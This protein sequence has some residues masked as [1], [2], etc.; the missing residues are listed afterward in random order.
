VTTARVLQ[1]DCFETLARLPNGAVQ[2]VIT[3]PPYTARST[4]ARVVRRARPGERTLSDGRV[5]VSAE[6]GAQVGAWDESTLVRFAT[7]CLRVSQRWVVIF[8]ELESLGTFARL[9]GFVRSMIWDRHSTPQITGDRPAQ[10]AEGIAVLRAAPSPPGLLVRALRLYGGEVPSNPEPDTLADLIESGAVELVRRADADGL[11]E[12]PT[13]MALLHNAGRKRWNGGGK[14]G[15]YRHPVERGAG[16]LHPAQKPGK[17]I[18]DLI[19]DFTDPG[20]TILDPCCGVGTIPA[21]AAGAGRQGAGFESHPVW[22]RRA[23]MRV[24]GDPAWCA[25][26]TPEEQAALTAPRPAA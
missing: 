10:P 23:A 17:L 13:A 11:T 24:S 2:H 22:A 3:D 8:C 7:E 26:L 20:D 15:I 5:D 16:R 21:I 4:K 14:R 18:R 1:A 25:A 12:E 19:D 6:I 9:P